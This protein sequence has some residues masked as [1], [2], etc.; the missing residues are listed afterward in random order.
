MAAAMIELLF[1]QWLPDAPDYANPGATE[2][3][4]VVP[5][6]DYY[7]PMGTLAP[8]TNALNEYCRGAI[9]TVDTDG[10]VYTFAGD[11]N[12]LYRLI[13]GEWVAVSPSPNYIVNERD[14]WA[15]AKFSQFDDLRG[16]ALVEMAIAVTP[17]HEVQYMVLGGSNFAPLIESERKPRARHV[18]VIREHL[19]L[20][21]TTDSLEGHVSDR[22]WWSAFR[23]ARDFDP[24]NE[25]LCDYQDLPNGGPVQKI[26]NM[27][28]GY[29]LIF[30][31]RSIY[32]MVQEGLPTIFRF[33]EVQQNRGTIAPGS[34]QLWGNQIYFIAE[35]GF[36]RLTE[37]QA[38]EPIGRERVDGFFLKDLDFNNRHRISSAICT[39]SG[40]VW[41]LYPG[42]GN[43]EG[44]PNRMLI[45]NWVTN[46]WS[47]VEIEVELVLGSL[48]SGYTLEELDNVSESLDL[49]P[50]SLD[51]KEWQGGAY[52][53]AGFSPMHQMG[54]FNGAPLDAVIE[55]A[56]AQ[57]FQ[58]RC[59]YTSAVWPLIENAGTVTMETGTRDKIKDPVVWSGESPENA[60]GAHDFN[61]DARYQRVRVKISG[62]FSKA[63]GVHVDTQPSGFL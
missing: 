8:I 19:V 41:W 5:A 54:S 17:A 23:D 40:C 27:A 16:P 24:S 48:S 51:S 31:E 25:T 9:S 33:D 26:V 1:P 38:A 30:K 56:E 47:R 35:D 42:A 50:A 49:L 22:V 52:A 46:R 29:G 63:R 13:A 60:I 55:T 3:L 44:L 58:P 32:R 39:R 59:S 15:F 28:P 34:V 2:A 62:G 61:I 14:S 7:K 18:A 12:D 4:N 36:Y 57:P 45:Y 10:N 53:L 11:K 37:G 6:Q 21:D 20:G 43:T